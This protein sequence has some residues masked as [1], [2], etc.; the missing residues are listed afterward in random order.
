M[1]MPFTEPAAPRYIYINPETNQVHLLVPVVGGQEISTDNTCKS[2]MSI[3]QFFKDGAALKELNVYKSALEFDLQLIEDDHSQ[4]ALKQARLNQ[5]NTYIAAIPA[6]QDKYLAKITSLLQTPSNLYSMQLRP[7]IQD[8]DSHV[9]N[10]IFSLKRDVNNETGEASSALYNSL[11][12]GLLNATIQPS[13][14]QD[15]LNKA[16][17]DA[18]LPKGPVVDFKSIQNALTAQWKSLFGFDVNFTAIQDDIDKLMGFTAQNPATTQD[19]IDALLGMCAANE[20]GKMQ[21]SPFYGKQGDE[22]K[23]EKL[24]MLTQFFLA[25]LNI[26]C[27][28]NRI[29]D[30]NFGAVL[31][32]SSDLSDQVAAIVV[33]SL[34]AGISVEVS[35]CTFFNEHQVDFGLSRPLTE[36]DTGAIQQKFARTYITVT[37]TK[38]NPHMDDFMILDTTA[39]AGKFVMHQGSICVD[40]AEL[41]DSSLT[42]TWSQRHYDLPGNNEHIKASVN[43]DIEKLVSSVNNEQLEKLP[44]NIRFACLKS[45]AYKF[46]TFLHNVAQGKQDEVEKSLTDNTY[47]LFPTTYMTYNPETTQSLPTTGKLLAD[48]SKEAQS[49]LITPGVF[50]DYSGRTFN[51]TAYEYAYWAKDTHMCRMLEARMDEPTKAAMLKRIDAIEQNGLK[52]EQ[53][54]HT[55]EGSKHFDMTPLKTALQNY[56][57]GYNTWNATRNYTAMTAAWELVGAAQRDLPVHVINEYCRPDRSFN[58]VPE[59]NE[60][61]LPRILTYHNMNTNSVAPLFPLVAFGSSGLGVDFALFRCEDMAG[62]MGVRRGPRSRNLA[63]QYGGVDLTAVSR[64]DEVRTADLERSR[65]NLSPINPEHDLG[66]SI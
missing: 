12:T 41:T 61:T 3:D 59:F 14:P 45:P 23:T 52:Y 42:N 1:Q 21:I 31:D 43:I 8:P 2:T 29:S 16:V 10:P 27:K 48:N 18:L 65:E 57:N 46:R 33:S 51:C 19:Y 55:V 22:N 60:D 38:E 40:F 62:G 6:M 63:F 7:S 28:A 17:I 64:L 36:V 30:A 34:D 56:V 50:T 58:P 20:W 15:K 39:L 35:L 26:Y 13:G 54:G 24:S 5:I 9:I 32:A 37:A 25:N 11:R 49:L 66:M 4:K 44:I 47:P 53:Q